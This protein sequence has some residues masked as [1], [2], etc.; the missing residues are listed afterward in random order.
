MDRG[1][2]NKRPLAFLPK[3]PPFGRQGRAGRFKNNKRGFWSTNHSISEYFGAL[4]GAAFFA[5][6]L[7]GCLSSDE[8]EALPAPLSESDLYRVQMRSWGFVELVGDDLEGHELPANPSQ[9]ELGQESYRQICLAC[10]GDWGQGL[11]EAWR[12]EWGEDMNCWQSKCHASNHPPE[13]FELPTMV[14][15]VL[16]PGSLSR[17]A[18]AEDL[19]Q[20][21]ALAMP[22]WNPGSLTDEQSW[23]LTAYLMNQRGELEKNVV[24]NPGNATFFRLHVDS[25]PR[26]EPGQAAIPLLI[27]LTVAFVALVVRREQK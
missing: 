6:V 17:F 10:H 18:S 5:L 14:P 22:W 19:Y 26:Q 8:T 20:N 7:A 23:A 9:L 27:L 16:G 24:L 12:A 21:I 11:T 2:H 25:P 3:R 15:A 13:G 1:T 4:V